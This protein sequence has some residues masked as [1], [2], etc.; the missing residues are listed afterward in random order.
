MT[1]KMK[2]TM[3]KISLFIALT[4]CVLV[5]CNNQTEQAA[6]IATTTSQMA[7]KV[8]IDTTQDD[9]AAHNE[10][11]TENQ[12]DTAMAT[13]NAKNGEEEQMVTEIAD[14]T[15][16]PTKTPVTN[17]KSNKK[18]EE[19][20]TKPEPKETKTEVAKKVTTSNITPPS[21]TVKQVTTFRKEV[22]V[23]SSSF[24]A[25]APKLTVPKPEKPKVDPFDAFFNSTDQFLKKYV[26]GGKVAYGTIKSNSSELDA[27][28]NQIAT[29]NLNSVNSD[30]K[31]AF[32]INAY[33]I[34]VIKAVVDNYP[35]A[36][37]LDKTGFFKSIPHT[38]AGESLT[39]DQLEKQKLMGIKKDA[40]FHFVLVCAAEGCPR[41]ENFAY[42]PSKLNAQLDKQ[43]RKAVNDVKF[44]QIND[45]AK[46]VE[47]SKIFEWYQGDFTT[48]GK[49]LLDYLNDYRSQK[50]PDDYEIDYYEYDWKLNQK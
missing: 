29:I 3:N 37:P 50:I 32:L 39:L 46:K 1:I 40:R 5:A 41:L 45:G 12:N 48:G 38:I 16:T 17:T 35:L 10:A 2:T 19:A 26:S 44:T 49:T 24:K 25:E 23:E 31:Q 4:L 30:T 14:V 21:K 22:V 13:D 18:K 47:L 8:N 36:S 20:K 6:S 15:K 43:T 11:A 27:L 42:T 9:M 28:V 34:S 7:T 33:N